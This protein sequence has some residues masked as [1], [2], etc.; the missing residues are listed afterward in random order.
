VTTVVVVPLSEGAV[1]HLNRPSLAVWQINVVPVSL[2]V[3]APAA[4][5]N[6]PA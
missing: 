2:V 1:I 4:E 5:Q 6:S 3:V